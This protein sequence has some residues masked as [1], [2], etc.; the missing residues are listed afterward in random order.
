MGLLLSI[1]GS[2][3][4]LDCCFSPN[5]LFQG[6]TALK[7]VEFNPIGVNASII[8]NTCLDG[9]CI[10]SYAQSYL[11]VVIWKV[12]FFSPIS[13]FSHVSSHLSHLAFTDDICIANEDYASPLREV[14][15]NCERE[16]IGTLEG[17][18]YCLNDGDCS[19]YGEGCYCDTYSKKC[20]GALETSEMAFLNC[21][22][23]NI[24]T[25]SKTSIYSVLD[26]A[27][28]VSNETSAGVNVTYLTADLLHE[29][30]LDGEALNFFLRKKN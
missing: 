18:R 21:I 15:V 9:A 12:R 1:G 8:D 5:A 16:W 28:L 13:Y 11:Y 17:G 27:G 14:V 23:D 2:S 24:D 29:Y 26:R 30:C 6:R 10:Q 3:E 25:L 7:F 4:E 20:V 22:I 19:K